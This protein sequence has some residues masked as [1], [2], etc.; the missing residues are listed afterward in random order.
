MGAA[1]RDLSRI[2]ACLFLAR[3]SRCGAI[4]A[5]LVEALHAAGCALPCALAAHV[6]SD[7]GR[8]PAAAP[9]MLRLCRDGWSDFF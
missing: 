2:A 5:A 4:R 3:P 1:S 9:A 7:G 8:R 6:I